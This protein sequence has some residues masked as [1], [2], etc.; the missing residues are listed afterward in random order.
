M[1]TMQTQRTSTQGLSLKAGLM[2][3]GSLIIYFLL[4]KLLGLIHHA[5]LR[6]FNFFIAGIGL[7]LTIRSYKTATHERVNYLEGFSLGFYTAVV[8]AVAFSVFVYV[9]LL[10]DPGLFLQLKEDAPVMGK[11]FT[12]LSA[13]V[14]VMAEGTISGLILSFALMQYFKNDRR[15]S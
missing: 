10:L 11:Y 14:T 15:H 7:F 1:E 12:P 5:E 3:A 6:A 2:I 9:Y 8:S 13:A 4:M